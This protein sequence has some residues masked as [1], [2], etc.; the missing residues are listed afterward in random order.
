MRALRHLF[1]TLGLTMGFYS[2][3][4]PDFLEVNNLTQWEEVLNISKSSKKLIYVYLTADDCEACDIMMATGL[5]NPTV[6]SRLAGHYIPVRIN[7]KTPFGQRFIY[8]FD[9]RGLPASIWMTGGEFVWALEEGAMD[10]AQLIEAMDAAGTLTRNYPEWIN[11]GL[12]LRP[13][14]TT[15]QWFQLFF[16][17]TVNQSPYSSTLISSFKRS[18]STDSLK[19]PAYWD[20]I[21]TYLTD[22]RS[23][24]LQY[25]VIAP[26]TTLGPEFPWDTYYSDLYSHNLDRAIKQKDSTLADIIA[27]HL[28]PSAP[29]D[30]T[31]SEDFEDWLTLALWQEYFLGTDDFEAYFAI[32]DDY[33]TKLAPTSDEIVREVRTLFQ[34]SVNE[35][36][37]K[38]ADRWVS[39]GLE[40]EETVELYIIHA[41]VNVLLG[42]HSEALTAINNANVLS[43]SPEQQSKL[44]YL[45]YVITRR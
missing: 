19:N 8:G 26:D 1:I 2:T 25:I 30:S 6:T 39:E 43:P 29:R 42:D 14:L 15:E 4:Q 3:A 35:K 16:V 44:D 23:P 27:I 22:L 38:T 5:S 40:R 36:A 13:S 33:M 31:A 20:F 24:L 21:Q 10:D 45:E 17:T 28:I 32:T 12:S 18:L 37:L 9:I 41:D 7:G 11:E 34:Y